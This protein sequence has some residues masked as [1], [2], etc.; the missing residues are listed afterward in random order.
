MTNT[1]YLLGFMLLSFT[2]MG[3]SACGSKR[4]PTGG[5]KDTTRPEVLA[6]L[7]SEYC[8]ISTGIVEI[9]FSKPM[10]RNSLANSIYIYP[11]V[12]NK[13]VSLDGSTLKIKLNE[14]LKQDTN[15]FVTLS[16]RLKDTRGNALER[17]QTLVFSNGKLSNNRVAGNIIYEE[18]ADNGLPVDL[19]L[20]SADSLLVY[21][22]RLNGTVFVVDNLNTGK[23]ILRSYIDKNLNGRY[24]FGLEPFFEDATDG[25][26]QA[27]LDVNL[28]YADTSKARIKSVNVI[29]NRELQVLFT[30]PV[31]RFQTINISS[32]KP[33]EID[34]NLIE[35][36]R[37]SILTAPMDSIKY[38]LYIN[39]V[40]DKK[41]NETEP[42][43]YQFDGGKKT[44]STAPFITHTNPRNGA[45]VNTLSPILELHFSEIIPAGAIYVKL[46]TGTDEITLKQ[47]SST[48]RIHRFQPTKDLLNYRSHTLIV[49]S[50][51]K[52]YSGN[53][54]EK[55]YELQ[56]LPLKR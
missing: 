7:P 40:V 52:D 9:S 39:G 47:L 34:Y 56:F 41:G 18:P 5:E 2:L 36:N 44:D 38:K 4:N 55:D 14:T 27:N 37:F 48:G 12:Q 49:L 3:L 31:V 16:T 53:K 6:T 50:N 10:D 35:N 26:R 51:T 13:K 11:P 23:H 28:A 43:E 32:T 20:F 17:N 30:E 8:D 29:S 24:D 19:S 22:N 15:Y 25:S 45:S 1:K 46:I 54:L 33:L 21:A 42:L